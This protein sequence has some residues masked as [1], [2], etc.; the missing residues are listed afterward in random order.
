MHMREYINLLSTRR[1][2]HL[3]LSISFIPKTIDRWSVTSPS[4]VE[5]PLNSSYFSYTVIFKMTH[6]GRAFSLLALAARVNTKIIPAG[7]HLEWQ[8]VTQSDRRYKNRRKFINWTN[9]E[10]LGTDGFLTACAGNWSRTITSDRTVYN[11][12][13]LSFSIR[14]YDIDE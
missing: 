4:E 11:N 14:R 1:D 12:L 6:R 8:K 7:W 2:L 10:K 3:R 9:Y 5:C 13:S